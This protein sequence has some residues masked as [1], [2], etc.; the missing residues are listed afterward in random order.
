MTQAGAT[1]LGVARMEET[2]NLRQ[3]G[4]EAEIMVLGYTSPIM[5]P[6]AIKHRIHVAIYDVEMAQ[7]Y[8]HF[9]K[10]SGQL[11]AHLKV[12]TGMGRLGMPVNQVADFSFQICKA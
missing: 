5:I 12:E 3:S 2:I 10:A 6:E 11:K 8:A 9:A 4:I 7:T 1:W